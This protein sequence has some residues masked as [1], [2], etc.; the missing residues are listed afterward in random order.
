MTPIDRRIFL[1]LGGA[2]ALAVFGVSAR[3]RGAEE[4]P[5]V[6]E[7]ALDP[8]GGMGRAVLAGR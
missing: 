6:P 5:A 8:A 3:S 2:V 7:P 4:A 1:S